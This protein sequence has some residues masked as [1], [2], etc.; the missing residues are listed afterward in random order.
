MLTGHRVGCVSSLSAD[1]HPGLRTRPTRNKSGSSQP[2]FLSVAFFF[3]AG[4][5]SSVTPHSFPPRSSSPLLFWKELKNSST[6][7]YKWLITSCRLREESHTKGQSYGG[8]QSIHNSWSGVSWPL[9]APT[10][11]SWKKDLTV[12]LVMEITN[13]EILEQLKESA[14]KVK[15][16][17]QS[18]GLKT[19]LAGIF[20][21]WLRL[22]YIHHCCEKFPLAGVS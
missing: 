8:I 20:K 19:N 10:P 3:P 2:E 12:H 4:T 16:S 9:L 17:R 22:V 15:N 6:L 18:H 5:S 13:M 11:V 14:C 1:F 21:K 7:R